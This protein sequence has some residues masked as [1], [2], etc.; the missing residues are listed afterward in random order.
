MIACAERNIKKEKKDKSQS[1][2]NQS[3]K[4][5]RGV[6]KKQKKKGIQIQGHSPQAM[7]ASSDL[8]RETS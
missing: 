5:T 6:R 4:P 1:S 8:E 7:L 3:L 2:I